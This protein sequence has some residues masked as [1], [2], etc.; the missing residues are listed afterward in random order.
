MSRKRR[1]LSD[2]A[3]KLLKLF[4]DDPVAEHHGFALIAATEI[5]SGTLYPALRLLS[6]T[7][8]FLN[9]RWEDVERAAVNRPP[10]RLYRLNGARADEAR[11]ALAEYE[12]HLSTRRRPDVRL[13]T[14]A[15]ARVRG[16]TA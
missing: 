13:P 7:R 16:V 8:G 10:R 11:D 9:S 1:V 15:R 2:P 14:P 12:E 4:I 5:G 3:A 6:E